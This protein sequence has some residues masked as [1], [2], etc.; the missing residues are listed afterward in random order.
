MLGAPTGTLVHPHD[1]E[2]RRIGLGCNPVDVV[3]IATTF[4][5]MQEEYGL[6][7]FPL[8]LP[9]A[10]PDQLSVGSCAEETALSRDTSQQVSAGPVTGDEGHQMTIAEESRGYKSRKGGNMVLTDRLGQD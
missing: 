5:P 9:M 10:E 1:I 3:G 8:G 4:K 6:S 7:G 2:S